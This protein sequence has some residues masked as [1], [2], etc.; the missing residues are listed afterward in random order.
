MYYNKYLF[1]LIIL[2]IMS[3]NPIFA[4]K[5]EPT[6]DEKLNQ[7]FEWLNQDD[8]N[9]T[10]FRS[11]SLTKKSPG[12]LSVITS[13]QI[14]QMGARDLMDV[15]NTVPGITIFRGAYNY[16]LQTRGNLTTSSQDVLLM[17]NGIPVTNNYIGSGIW[18]YNSMSVKFIERVEVIRGPASSL[19]GAN[20]FSAIINVITKTVSDTKNIEVSQKFGSFGH[21]QTSL[22]AGKQFDSGL[23]LSLF[24]DQLDTD[25][26]K[27]TVAKDRQ[28]DL[29]GLL[30]TGASLAPGSTENFE[31]KLELSAKLEYEQ[32]YF[33]TYYVDKNRG[34]NV[35]IY[36]AL[37]DDSDLG[38]EDFLM[39]FGFSQNLNKK[40]TLTPNFYYH[41]NVM[42]NHIE[43]LPPGGIWPYNGVPYPDGLDQYY[44]VT[45][46]R[47]GV[48]V[49]LDWEISQS[50]TLTLGTTYEKMKQGDVFQ[51]GN[52]YFDDNGDLVVTPWQPIP[53]AYSFIG[54]QERNFSALY[55]ENVYDVT[56]ELRLTFGARYD[57][58]D[59]FGGSLNPRL[60]LIYE[61][62]PGYDV[63]LMYGEAFRAPSFYEMYNNHPFVQGNDELD[64]EEITTY[65]ISFGVP[66]ND[67]LKTRVTFF[68]NEIDDSIT[69]RHDSS[70]NRIVFQNT[71][72]LKVLGVEF[73]ARYNLNRGSYLSF[74]YTYLDSEDESTGEAIGKISKQYFSIASNIRLN[75]H[76]NWYTG[77]DWTD[78]QNP[79]PEDGYTDYGSS[80]YVVNTGFQFKEFIPGV[81]DLSA[82]FHIYNLF[83]RDYSM[84]YSDPLP[85]GAPMP[86]RQFMFELEYK[87]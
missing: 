55:M 66:V 87:F 63:K 18:S 41:K 75:R 42:K 56:D 37:N 4:D 25:G 23:K 28:T 49:K 27:G 86:G 15:I 24:A 46:E 9:T 74:N 12:S 57:H 29:D 43:Y 22:I 59:D 58:Y 39:N 72:Q 16:R 82:N 47:Y 26:H 60:G 20:A 21:K 71:E 65:E 40:L 11:K 35:G 6:L 52:H 13:D 84:D 70:T 10:A 1:Q 80:Y 44:D 51:E 68:Y 69:E 36:D 2:T 7:E 8:Y 73:E 33:S 5:D 61:Y 30:G 64:P 14:E 79:R 17:I 38:V 19:Y 83:D 78:G 81:E 85:G 54:D 48:D 45:N 67:R 31:D 50:Y 34:P 53:E 32:F 62:A 3:T 77:I 76:I